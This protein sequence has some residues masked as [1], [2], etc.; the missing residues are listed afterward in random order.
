MNKIGKILLTF[1]VIFLVLLITLSFFAYP[2]ADD[3]FFANSLNK[4]GWLGSQI[5][6]YNTWF[7]RFSSTMLLVSA[8]YIDFSILY[9]IFPI[10]TIFGYLFAFYLASGKLFPDASRQFKLIFSL[11]MLLLYVSGMPSL[12]QEFYWFTGWA[13]YAP[14]NIATIVFL[15]CF[16]SIKNSKNYILLILLGIFAIGSNEISML[17]L[18]VFVFIRLLKD[19]KNKRLLWMFVVF[20][21]SSLVVV[22]APG[23]AVRAAKEHDFLFSLVASVGLTGTLIGIWLLNPLLW[24]A[25][26]LFSHF[27]QKLNI[28]IVLPKEKPIIIVCFLLFL[29]FCAPFTHFWSTGA[30]APGRTL[31]IS[32]LV[33]IF[34]FAYIV[35][36]EKIQS[37]MT[38]I[39]NKKFLVFPVFVLWLIGNFYISSIDS[40]PKQD[41]SFYK[42]HPFAALQWTLTT[43]GQNN[44]YH[45]YVDLFSG[46]ASDFRK[47]M[48]DREEKIKNYKGGLIC[49]PKVEKIP[50]SI[51]YKD[52]SEDSSKG[53]NIGFAEYYH[54]EKVAVCNDVMKHDFSNPNEL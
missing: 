19:F 10:L 22:L 21:L 52:L 27:R 34:L 51:F 26:F 49:L 9:K 39:L 47:T 45:V 8:G 43:Y 1:E 17:F 20:T 54:L 36:L 12:A 3:F 50:K 32:F 13:T 5:N 23:N 24:I 31:N 14:A 30:P 42:Q 16:D 41:F 25:A 48:L 11:T 37:V 7:G 46:K 4:F 15:C 40:A 6:W 29:I 35:S 33:F 2:Q 53:E 18:M 44:L 38:R 28:K